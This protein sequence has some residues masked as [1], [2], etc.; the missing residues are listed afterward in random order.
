VVDSSNLP[1]LLRATVLARLLSDALDSP[2]LEEETS[3]RFRTDL[4]ALNAQLER[5]LES[6]EQSGLRLVDE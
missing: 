3:D 6:A 5:K 2:G 4:R 1:A